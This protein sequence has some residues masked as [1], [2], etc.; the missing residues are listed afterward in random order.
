MGSPSRLVDTLVLSG[1]VKREQDPGDRRSVILSL[2][3]AGKDAAGRARAAEAVLHAT[4]VAAVDARRMAAASDVLRALVDGRPAGEAI[5][6]K[7]AA[8]SR[9]R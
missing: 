1:L 8:A 6:E 4:I 3:D 2:T 7:K 5:E 9:P